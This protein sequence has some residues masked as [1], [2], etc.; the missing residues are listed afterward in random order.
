MHNTTDY[1][2]PVRKSPSLH[3]Q[4]SNSNPKFLGMAEAYFVCHISPKFHISLIYAFIGCGLSVVRAQHIH[5][6][7][8]NSIVDKVCQLSKSLLFVFSYV[9]VA[10]TD[11]RCPGM[12]MFEANAVAGISTAPFFGNGGDGEQVDSFREP[13]VDSGLPPKNKTTKSP[14]YPTDGFKLNVAVR[15][16]SLFASNFPSSAVAK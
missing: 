14:P 9:Q 3:G 16:D 6:G 12:T 4:K 8:A 7:N 10:M 15:Y 13:H 2:C 5:F 1:G 11:P